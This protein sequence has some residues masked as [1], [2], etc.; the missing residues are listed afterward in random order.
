MRIGLPEWQCVSVDS[1]GVPS[2]GKWG[3]PDWFAKKLKA[4]GLTLVWSRLHKNFGIARRAAPGRYI[5]QMHCCKGGAGSTPIPLGREL[6]RWV[7][8]MWNEA[9][10]RDTGEINRKIAANKAKEKY[11]AMVAEATFHQ[12]S[13]K[14]VENYVDFHQGYRSP[15][16]TVA[17][18]EKAQRARQKRLRRR[19]IIA[20]V[21]AN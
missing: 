8:T 1:A 11:D 17:L 12:D 6:L 10:R 9:K 3:R 7:L 18:G 4:V 5:W 13:R 19:Q 2:G 16:V 14:E 15:R 20:T 21:G